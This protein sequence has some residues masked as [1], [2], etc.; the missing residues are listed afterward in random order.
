[1]NNQTAEKKKEWVVVSRHLWGRKLFLER[2]AWMSQASFLHG[3][4]LGCGIPLLSLS[5]AL[6]Q[7]FST[8]RFWWFQTSPITDLTLSAASGTSH[9]QLGEK[10]R[11]NETKPNRPN[12]LNQ[13]KTI[14]T[15]LN[16][17][18]PDYNIT[19]INYGFSER[20]FKERVKRAFLTLTLMK[21]ASR[22]D[23]FFLLN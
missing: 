21:N 17:T 8:V 6:S 5:L 3:S 18:K 20:E 13:L 15:L 1:M 9:R 19:T 10:K 23:T 22:S 11:K 7:A 16:Q 4:L 2:Q 14:Q 12:L